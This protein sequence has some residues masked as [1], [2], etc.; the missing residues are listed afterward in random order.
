MS[1]PVTMTPG[2]LYEGFARVEDTGPRGMVSLRGGPKALAEM[3]G[4][5]GLKLPEPRQIT[6]EAMRL[7]WMSPDELLL[8]CDYADAPGLATQAEEAAGDLH[9]LVAV[10][11]DAR[12]VFGVTGTRAD[13]VLRKLTPANLDAL[14]A[15]EI[16]RTRLSQV[17]AGIWAVE[18]GYEVMCF[19]S[20]APYVFGLLSNAAQMGSELNL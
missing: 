2:A 20:Y 5:L 8:L 13:E 12:A 14:G 15:S 9:S 3:A 6:G 10:V 17:A 11:S 18:G 1:D 7:A 16:R 19:R 4:A